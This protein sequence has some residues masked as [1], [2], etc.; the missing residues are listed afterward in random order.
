M[1]FLGRREDEPTS[2]DGALADAETEIQSGEQ[3]VQETKA[4][5]KEDQKAA[6][7]EERELKTKKRQTAAA[8]RFGYLAAH[9][10]KALRKAN[11]DK[12]TRRYAAA[13]TVAA[14]VSLT[15]QFTDL[16][17]RATQS[18]TDKYNSFMSLIHGLSDTSAANDVKAAPS[19]STETEQAFN[20]QPPKA[21][22]ANF[23]EIVAE[24]KEIAEREQIQRA[25]E[26]AL[27]EA[28][29]AAPG[30]G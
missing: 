16:D 11:R 1:R 8:K 26:Q 17:E 5:I 29:P 21:R 14:V 13:A 30:Q 25:V 20:A 6:A 22:P 4:R 27:E 15:A 3:H 9:P 18:L 19:L 7:Q 12:W 2:I 10:D 24:A 28:G 23:A